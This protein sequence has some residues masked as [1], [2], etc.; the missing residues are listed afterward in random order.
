MRPFPGTFLDVLRGHPDRQGRHQNAHPEA[1]R[2]H[3]LQRAPPHHP[4]GGPRHPALPGA[5][6]AK[7]LPK[8]PKGAANE[9]QEK[10]RGHG[11]P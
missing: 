1:L 4:A 9:T 6:P 11:G 7:L 8:L 2:H 10:T 5:L 3:R